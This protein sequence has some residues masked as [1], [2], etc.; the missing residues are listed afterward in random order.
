MRAEEAKTTALV[1]VEPAEASEDVARALGPDVRAVP[2]KKLADALARRGMKGKLHATLGDADKRDGLAESLRKAGLGGDAIVVVSIKSWKGGGREI[3]SLAIG[4]GARGDGAVL[5]GAGDDRV[6]GL[7]KALGIEPRA[8]TA[9]PKEA[10][11][12]TPPSTTKTEPPAGGDSP[13]PPRDEPGSKTSDAPP[14]T[15]P[16]DPTRALASVFAGLEIGTRRL[17][18]TDALSS[19]VRPYDVTGA[20]SP[21][22][23]V[24]LYPL[25]RT[26]VP[27]VRDLGLVA[28]GATAVGLASR[29]PSGTSV[30]TRWLRYELALRYRLR[31]D[32]RDHPAALGF[33]L[34]YS[35]IQFRISDPSAL[36]GADPSV[37]DRFL[38][39]GL[40]GRVPLGPVALLARV[41]VGRLFA[42][43]PMGEQFGRG[44][45]GI[46]DARLGVAAPLA[47]ILEARL[48]VEHTRAFFDFRPLPGDAYVAGGA[49][50]SYSTLHLDG[51]VW[52]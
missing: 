10:A 4:T 26:S 19:N 9:A 46:V 42:V 51:L 22:V 14:A 43:G 28:S 33:E 6:A 24:E 49:V 11:A 2:S 5:L 50:D 44:R 34:G 48:W 38:R 20:P 47:A 36:G 13:P 8:A 12:P 25:A 37:D 39:F 3:R 32:G 27:F 52:F 7:R 15:D 35:A 45:G 29:L 23:G 21:T 40:D 41:G 1:Y 31:L 17:R 16:P 30:A 18:Y